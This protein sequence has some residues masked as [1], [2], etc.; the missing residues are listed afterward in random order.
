MLADFL[1]SLFGIGNQSLFWFSICFSLATSLAFS[2]LFCP[3]FIR[4]M[5]AKQACQ[6]IRQDIALSHDHKSNTPTM[7]GVVILLSMLCSLVL[8]ADWD[9]LAIK[10]VVMIF[11]TYGGIGALDD[12]L[13]LK[14]QHSDGLPA[15]W[16]YSLQS[17]FALIAVVLLY[18]QSD[19]H[20][21]L[22]VP[23]LGKGVLD[24][25]IWF[26]P[27]AYCVIVGASNAVNLTDG[28]DGLAIFP[29]V[30]VGVGLGVIAYLSMHH[31]MAAAYSLPELTQISGLVIFCVSLVGA[32]LG[33][34]WFNALPA[35]IFM[36]DVGALAIGGGLGAVSVCL[37]QEFL[38]FVMGGVFVAETL[39]V[40]LQVASFKMRGKRI[41]KMAPL[42][43]HFE[44]Q[45]LLES[46]I[47]IRF[48]LVSFGLVFSTLALLRLGLLF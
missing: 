29:S 23:F 18:S 21:M 25:G 27:L 34:L 8:W 45:G 2:L 38:L 12:Y 47:I 46:Q 32:G 48:W 42:H 3:Y 20:H 36:G 9:G 6:P 37:H 44:L 26:I 39:S 15:R 30:L 41:F 40:I 22:M 13:K 43:H 14:Y 7:G 1:Q 16:K 17:I 11:C 24:L 4:R 5:R 10:L 33:F 28:L 19:G 31:P 35:K